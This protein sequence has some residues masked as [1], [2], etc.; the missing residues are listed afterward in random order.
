M[1]SLLKSPVVFWGHRALIFFSTGRSVTCANS[2]RSASYDR[3]AAIQ[4]QTTSRQG[5]ASSYSRSAGSGKARA[6][7]EKVID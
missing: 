7:E 3:D 5:A 2:P 1:V 4:T 6:R